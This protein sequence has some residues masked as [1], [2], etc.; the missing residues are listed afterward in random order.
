MFNNF[1]Y[2]LSYR[3]QNENDLSDITW[4]MCETS[5]KF[6][7]LF[8]KFFFDFQEED[9]LKNIVTFE[10][11]KSQGNSRPD[12]YI[13]YLKKREKL[14]YLIEV[15]IYDRNHHFEQYVKTFKLKDNK[16]RLGYITNYPHKEDGFIIKTWEEFYDFIK[17]K[18]PQNEEEK[19][20]WLGYLEYLKSVCSIIKITK[21]MDLTGFYS[22]YLFTEALKK[23]LNNNENKIS[24]EFYKTT[25]KTTNI[26]HYFKIKYPDIYNI[27]DTWAW[28]G[29][30]F[31]RE[32]PLI[33]LSF[34]SGENWG[35]PVYDILNENF[36]RIKNSE[37]SESPY[38]EEGR[39][40]FE[41]TRE[42]HLEF[43]KLQTP[44]EQMDILKKFINDVID[45][46]LKI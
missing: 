29:I 26:G 38:Y 19:K 14:I 40:W 37:F 5:E 13:E 10:R 39:I 36:T 11:E 15:K 6:K 27:K 9:F 31:N 44:E 42:K 18:L 1:L 22:L 7:E 21:K 17:E 32:Q 20:L 12:F 46:P 16:N 23:V 35:K 41:M 2:N 28:I 34:D 30:Y 45:K 3:K 25:T 33:C 4:A 8:L 43:Q 24:T